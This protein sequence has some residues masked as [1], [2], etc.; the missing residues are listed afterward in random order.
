MDPTVWGLILACY[1]L[2][3]QKGL[4]DFIKCR[5]R[6]D[7]EKRE[8]LVY[9]VQPNGLHPQRVILDGYIFTILSIHLV[10]MN[11]K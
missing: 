1:C 10:T 8:N 2:C 6:E 5:E 9:V 7:R 3:R 4:L 11:P